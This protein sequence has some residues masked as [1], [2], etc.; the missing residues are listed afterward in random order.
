LKTYTHILLIL[1]L[2]LSCLLSSCAVYPASNARSV[3]T[4]AQEITQ[5]ISDFTLSSPDVAEGGTLSVEYTCDGTSATLALTWSGAPNGTQS[6]AVI[7]HHVA[8][9]HDV[10]WYWVLY[11][12][13][14]NVT[15]L[16]KNSTGIGSLGTNSVNDKTAYAPPCSKGPGAKAYTYT[17]YALSRQPE[18]PVPASQ[19]S[20]DVLLAA[21]QNI[22]L[23][24][25]E[26]NV[27]YTRKQR[28][29]N[30]N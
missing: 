27:T 16:S 24:S 22:T 26:L 25:T 23:A 2:A 3:P 14:E 29:N 28:G 13:P 20:R 1:L 30:E 19:V 18:L 10:H 7:M 4:E 6:Y 17:I 5:E 9:P 21:I 15:S 11:G 8:S 12:I